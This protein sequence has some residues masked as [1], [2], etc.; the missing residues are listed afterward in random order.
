MDDVSFNFHRY[1]DHYLLEVISDNGEGD[2]TAR[3]IEFEIE[4]DDR[5]LVAPYEALPQSLEEDIRDWLR[6]A[7]FDI[8]DRKIA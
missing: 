3:S 4:D 6:N 7:G 5:G 8:V 1:E 2:V